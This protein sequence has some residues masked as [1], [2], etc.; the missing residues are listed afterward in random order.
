M[1]SAVFWILSASVSIRNR[2]S[3]VHACVYITT[4]FILNVRFYVADL[5]ANVSDLLQIL[6]F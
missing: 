5:I 4:T 3:I 2:M 1:N 6:G